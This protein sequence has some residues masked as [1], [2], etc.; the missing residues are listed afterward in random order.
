MA[1]GRMSWY[2]IRTAGGKERKAKE[3]IESE[4][5]R[6]DLQDDIA[7]VLIPTEKIVTIKGGKKVNSERI[8]FPGY[9]LIEANM[10]AEVQHMIKDVPNVAGFLSE[11]Q[12]KDKNGQPVPL[13]PAEVNRILG[14]VDEMMESEIEV[15]NPF[16]TGEPVKITDGP[17]NGF[18]GTIKEIMA[19]KKKLK[20]TVKIF[21]RETLLELNF[22][23]V[24]KE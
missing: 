22:A 14:R 12:G 8:F 5:Q 24:V 10:T 21:G 20:V 13:R 2:V 16:I 7:Q 6:L 3:Y 17:F 4:I 1:E 9:V 18:D 19:D 23:Q 11:R 15:L